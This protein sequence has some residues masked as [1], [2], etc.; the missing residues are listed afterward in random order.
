MDPESRIRKRIPKSC[1][2]CHR[3]KQRCVGVPTCTNCGSAN[4][5]CS[6]A[7][8]APSWHHGMSKGALAHRIETLEAQL[9]AVL[10]RAPES[11]S[12]QSSGAREATAS[13]HPPAQRGQ[14]DGVVRFLTFGHETDGE[15][16]YL[17]PSSG[18]SIAENLGRI[19]HST[20]GEK[21]LP[22]NSSN[23]KSESWWESTERDNV[24]PPDDAVGSQ[25]LDAYFN[26]MHLR[27]PFLDRTEILDLHAQRYQPPGST[28]QGQFEKF[29]LFMVYA[30]GA[31]I[32]QMT[33]MYNSTPP[34]A[35]L[36]TALQFDPSYR[37]SLSIA[38]I[39]AMML[40]V[41]YNLRSTSNSSVWYMIGLA[42]RICVDFG[43]HREARYRDLKPHEAEMRRRLF[44]SVY[45]TE[46][47]TA[48]ALG[49]PFSIAEEEID[50]MPPHNLDDSINNDDMIRQILSN[51]A[52]IHTQ[53][54]KPT[55]GR[56][57]ASIQ[58]HR[59]VSQIH[60]RIYRVDKP[61]SQVLPEVAPLMASLQDYK[62]TLPSL[63]LEEKEFVH[64]HW[65]NSLR[66]LLQPF[67]SILE[68][69]DK[70]IETCLSASGQMCQFFKRLQQRDSSGFSFLLVNSVFMAGL[71]MCFCLFRSPCL[72]T[73][74]VSNDLRACSSAI[75]MMAE[76]NPKLKKHRDGLETIINRAMEFVEESA[77][78]RSA[79]EQGLP[80]QGRSTG[81][82]PMHH[83]SPHG[84]L[85]SQAQQFVPDNLY[86]GSP[87]VL[88]P[89]QGIITED[90]WTGD[91]FSVPILE[92]FNWR[93]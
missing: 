60:T 34:K 3:R 91:T 44:W 82:Q 31:T 27:L 49:R 86:A 85:E 59:I 52:S 73:T 19:V 92:G 42:M 88:Y 30:I 79:S 65:N 68:P 69:Q 61:I 8:T 25:I 77:N 5:P 18:L 38:S 54:Q 53:P 6:R 16:A 43:F 39:E 22:V 23:Q 72:W 75:F 28:P 26:N 74:T 15:T 81:E 41:L 40:L 21:L 57:I 45:L 12:T 50:T 46:R 90:F 80:T 87:S 13:H 48:W 4:Q 20:V 93:I 76:R 11:T 17:G 51:D 1:R 83:T 2:R 62:Q 35:F 70:L 29:K 7:E 37:E 10:N 14:L 58:L 78:T 89:F 63:D 36:V 67:L 71:T 32:S 33:E 24:A 47:Y 55:I 84:S 64:M 9:A 66:I 56:F